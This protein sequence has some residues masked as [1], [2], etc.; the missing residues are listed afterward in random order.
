MMSMNN[1]PMGARPETHGTET[2]PP[3]TLGLVGGL[4]VVLGLL[5]MAAQF[6]DF[7]IGA[8]LWPLWVILPGL[9]L[10]AFGLLARDRSSLGLSIAGSI[11]TMVGIVLLFQQWTGAFQTWAYAWALVGPGGAAIGTILYAI[12]ANDSV[13]LREG[14]RLLG[15]AVAI[16]A[17]GFV[18]FEV[19]IGLSGFGL[20]FWA[21]PFLLIAAGVAFLA[22]AYLRR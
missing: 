19:I 1:D 15:I 16:F 5:W 20:G 11:V 6:L 21:W 4:L 9:A 10:L 13:R 8:N 12:K 18:F 3:R 14:T 22:Y 7:N 2:P 17:V